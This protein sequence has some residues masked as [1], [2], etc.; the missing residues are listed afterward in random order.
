PSY[1]QKAYTSGSSPE[2]WAIPELSWHGVWPDA[3]KRL[4][5]PTSQHLPWT[6]G[7]SPE[8]WGVPSLSWRGFAPDKVPWMKPQTRIEGFSFAL[9]NLVIIVPPLSWLGVWPDMTKSLSLL[10]SAMPS[11]FKGEAVEKFART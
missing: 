10:R 9:Q 2:K 7:T 1:Q 6:T 5:L 4:M 3:T 8:V 11:L